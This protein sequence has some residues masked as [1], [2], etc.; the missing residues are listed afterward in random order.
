VKFHGK[1]DICLSCI[2]CITVQLIERNHN[3]AH[4][5]C[6]AYSV[7]GHTHCHVDTVMS[8]FPYNIWNVG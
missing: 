6:V 4:N 2:L 1:D 7:N 8:V 3:R 5:F